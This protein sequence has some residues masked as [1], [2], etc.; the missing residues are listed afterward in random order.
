MGAEN[1]PERESNGCK[2]H[3]ELAS[4]ALGTCVHTSA[5]TILDEKSGAVLEMECSLQDTA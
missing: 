2:E 5:H 3:P 1:L 4:C